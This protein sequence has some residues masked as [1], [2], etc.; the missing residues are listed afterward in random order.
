MPEARSLS[1][2]MSVGPA[3][4]GDLSVLGITSVEQ[5]CGQEAQV[6]YDRLCERT[7]THHDICMLDV[8]A[9]AI[10][11]AEDPDLPAEQRSWWWWSRVR[12]GE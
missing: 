5:L 6:L 10:A 1:D 4:I 2:L 12:K 7:G 3:A 8:F 11:Q 9:A